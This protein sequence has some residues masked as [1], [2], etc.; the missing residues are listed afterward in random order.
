MYAFH[1]NRHKLVLDKTDIRILDILQ[2]N[3]EMQVNHIAT[4]VFKSPSS[5]HERI[6]KLEEKGVIKR[7]VAVLDRWLVGRPTLVVVMVQLKEHGI[8]ILHEFAHK[9][10]GY[11]EV[12]FCLHLSGEFDFVLHLTLIDSQEY[13]E[14]LEL[15][16][17]A[18]PMVHKVQSSFVLKEFKSMAALPLVL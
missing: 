5:T 4:K 12:Q 14:F 2:T 13:D 15:K 17:C 1:K 11:P 6:R 7:Y 18:H 8:D 16:L 3:A 10:T 9:M